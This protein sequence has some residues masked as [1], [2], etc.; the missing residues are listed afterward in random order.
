MTGGLSAGTTYYITS[1]SG[2]QVTPTTTRPVTT[3]KV[4]STSSVGNVL[5]C[6]NT[7]PYD[8]TT[9]LYVGMPITFSGVGLGGVNIDDT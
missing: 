7:A 9:A 3:V 8:N 1:Y 4:V 6:D 5:T 2:E